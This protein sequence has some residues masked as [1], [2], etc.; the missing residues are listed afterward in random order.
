MK[1][2]VLIFPAAVFSKTKLYLGTFTFLST[3]WN[4]NENPISR[5]DNIDQICCKFP[6][7]IW[8]GKKKYIRFNLFLKTA[9]AHFLVNH[10]IAVKFCL[11]R[12]NPINIHLAYRTTAM[13]LQY[14]W[15]VFVGYRFTSFSWYAWYLCLSIC[16]LALFRSTINVDQTRMFCPIRKYFNVNQIYFHY[17]IVSMNTL[18]SIFSKYFISMD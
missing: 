17:Y 16:Q 6:S 8:R 9:N 7:I 4:Y 3:D 5:Y 2:I 14:H 10:K 15:N 13:L 1:A 12:I 11:D 18:F